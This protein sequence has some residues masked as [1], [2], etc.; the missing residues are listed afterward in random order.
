M[1]C[2]DAVQVTFYYRFS[3]LLQRYYRRKV[4]DSIKTVIHNAMANLH[5]YVQCVEMPVPH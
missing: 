5:D 2:K 3:G 1:S 4:G